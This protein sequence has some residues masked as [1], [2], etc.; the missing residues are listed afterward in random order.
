MILDG[1][2]GEDTGDDDVL[3]G[4]VEVIEGGRVEEVVGGV[5]IRDV[6]EGVCDDELVDIGDGSECSNIKREIGSGAWF[7]SEELV[8]DKG[9]VRH[10]KVNRRRADDSVG[11][12]FASIATREGSASAGH[13]D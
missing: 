10:G 6:Y 13:S 12:A 8:G 11:G 5:P 9:S 3:G 2:V 4:F 1:S 7:V